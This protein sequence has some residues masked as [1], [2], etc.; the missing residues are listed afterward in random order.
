[1]AGKF[2]PC[3][4]WYTRAAIGVNISLQISGIDG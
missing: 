4:L 3:P 1:M 2:S